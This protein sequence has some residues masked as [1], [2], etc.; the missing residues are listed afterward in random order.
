[1]EFNMFR[2]MFA[3]IFRPR[4]VEVPTEHVE[5]VDEEIARYRASLE[6]KRQQAIERMGAKWILH[7]SH[8][9]KKKEIPENSLGF[10]TA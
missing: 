3:D 1:M 8:H 7:P 4:M 2:R 9:V 6:F 10:R 5:T